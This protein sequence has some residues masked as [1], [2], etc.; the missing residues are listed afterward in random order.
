MKNKNLSKP[1]KAI[2][3]IT[4]WFVGFILSYLFL[5]DSFGAS[6]QLKLFLY[7]AL[8]GVLIPV[9]ITSFFSGERNEFREADL[10][11]TRYNTDLANGRMI[12]QLN[13]LN[14]QIA[15]LNNNKKS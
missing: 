13:D 3:Y 6:E 5:K 12:S 7:S 2:L 10:N 8:G 14:E 4:Y 15:K 9:L 1:V 11:A